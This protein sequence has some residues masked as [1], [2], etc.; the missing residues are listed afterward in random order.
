MKGSNMLFT[1]SWI[2]LLI[3]SGA[4]ILFSAESL[5]IAYSGRPDG[6]SR[7]Y[8]L[9][10]IEEQGGQQAAKAFRGRRVTAATWA[11]GYALL[12]I[13]VTW[14]PYRRGER[15]AWWA[16]LASLGVSQLLSLA[17]AV[18]L[19]TTAGIATPALLLAFVLLAL[20]AGVP[21]MFTRRPQNA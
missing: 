17:R 16:L 13:G 2:L 7:E 19:A 10:Q 4:I 1:A 12:A 21:R 8:T 15:W 20:L 11:L 5:W 14:M 9:S 18:A 3:V 6:L